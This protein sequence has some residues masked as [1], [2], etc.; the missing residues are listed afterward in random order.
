MCRRVRGFS[1]L[2]FRRDFS[3]ASSTVVDTAAVA[4]CGYF[5]A[6]VSRSNRISRDKQKW[7]EPQ[8][9]WST[10]PIP[11]PHPSVNRHEP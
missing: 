6:L 10:L 8:I 9:R 2:R 4:V 1:T 11:M 3:F 7:R 5:L